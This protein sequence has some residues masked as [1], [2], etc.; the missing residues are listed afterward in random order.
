MIKILALDFDGVI[1][2]GLH[3]YFETS[4]RTYNQIWNQEKLNNQDLRKSFYTLRPVIES[5]WE[6][7]ILLRALLL[8]FSEAEILEN[9]SK[10][11]QEIVELED[12]T[13]KNIAE[14]LDAIRNTWIKTDLQTWLNLHNFY[15]GVIEKLNKIINSGLKLYIIT[16]KEGKFTRELLINQGVK[17]PENMI[18]GK[19]KKRPKYETLRQIIKEN[20]I[21]P[22][23]IYFVED[24]LPAL[25]L[26]NEQPDLK[27]VGL[28]LASWGYNTEKTRNSLNND[29]P[30]LKLLS[31]ETFTTNFP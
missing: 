3:E 12:L 1:C 26:V 23:E 20:Q 17:I 14:K 10:V 22:A 28:F 25:E 31:L 13:P 2:D 11:C 5:G 6:M 19:E 9:W 8:N 18:F 4:K 16:T 29:F 7:P 24:R 21:K 15:P 30:N 27:E